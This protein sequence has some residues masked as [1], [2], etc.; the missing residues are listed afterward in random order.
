[1]KKNV[2]ITGAGGNL[3]LATVDRFLKDGW[4][5]IAVVSPGKKL[6]VKGDIINLETD[7]AIESEVEARIRKS[8]SEV[9][10]I[11]AALLLAGGYASGDI[12]KTTASLLQKQYELNFLTAYNVARPVFAQMMKQ[13]SGGRIIFVGSRPALQAKDG[14]G[15]LA[16]ALAKSL[17][18]KLADFLNAEGS[19][20]NVTSTVIVPSTIDTPA[21]REGMPKADFSS[22]VRPEAIADVMA[23]AVSEK[24]GPLR[25]TVLKVYGRA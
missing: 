4:K 5:V 24:S 9:K 22:W 10:T 25:E 3:G 15:S 17:L 6:M 7:L 1:M 19:A 11:D 2:L 20:K 14:K 13:D 8:I 12:H 16:Y 21:N 23:F 18:F